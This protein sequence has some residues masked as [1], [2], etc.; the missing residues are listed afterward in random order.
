MGDPSLFV[1]SALMVSVLKTHSGVVDIDNKEADKG[2]CN[3]SL[4]TEVDG[5]VKTNSAENIVE[6]FENFVDTGD[7]NKGEK[8]YRET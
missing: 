3:N 7:V 6:N 8:M 2:R 5:T 1:E 4:N